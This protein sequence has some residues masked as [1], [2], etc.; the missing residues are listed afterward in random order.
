MDDSYNAGV[1]L[2]VVVTGRAVEESHCN[3]CAFTFDASI[4]NNVTVLAATNFNSG[5]TIT[6]NGSDLT[7]GKVFVDGE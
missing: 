1:P 3:S 7:G 6:I 2:N 5:D 4:S